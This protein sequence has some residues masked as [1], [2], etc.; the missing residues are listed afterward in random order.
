MLRK[1]FA[2]SLVEVL[3]AI[4]IVATLVSIAVPAYDNHRYKQQVAAAISDINEIASAIDRFYA[5]RAAFPDSLGDV[6][7]QNRKDP[8]GNDYEYLNI[9]DPANNNLER[10]DHNLK[11]VNSDYDLYSK[12]KDGN[13]N[14]PFNSGVSQ[15]DIVR[16]NNG[17]FIGLAADY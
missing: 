10:K 9:T 11:P 1:Q 14:K 5:N 7:M 17:R 8:W 6:G 15:D 4:A 16:A 12:G 13:S 3:I 2:F